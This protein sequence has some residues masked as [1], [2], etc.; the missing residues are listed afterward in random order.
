VLP[1]AYNARL[2]GVIVSPVAIFWNIQK[3]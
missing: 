2:S 3:K 1:T